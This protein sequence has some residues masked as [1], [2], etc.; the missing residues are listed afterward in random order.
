M[1]INLVAG[2]F[3]HMEDDGSLCI[4]SN[5]IGVRVVVSDRDRSEITKHG[6]NTETGTLLFCRTVMHES[7]VAH[8]GF[9]SQ[10]DRRAFDRIVRV[11]GCGPGMAMKLLSVYG[12]ESLRA[13]VATEDR[14][15][16]Y[17]VPGVGQK[18]ANK[19]VQELKL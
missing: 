16:L 10:D 14:N 11:D 15:A 6:E 18:T 4:W 13:I 9:L 1:N 2:R 3:H 17:R 5:D 19:L 7:S 12:A 8:Y